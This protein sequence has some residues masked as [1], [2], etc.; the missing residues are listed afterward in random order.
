VI[1]CC[2]QITNFGYSTLFSRGIG[3]THGGVRVVSVSVCTPSIFHLYIYM[4]ASTRVCLY[5]VHTCTHRS[6]YIAFIDP[7][8]FRSKPNK[9]PRNQ[10]V[11]WVVG[12]HALKTQQKTPCKKGKAVTPRIVQ[13]K[14]ALDYIITKN[15]WLWIQCSEDEAS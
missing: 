1:S 13:S 9:A 12:D 2:E 5:D 14:A 8:P 4:F 11:S 10:I 15:V 7:V 3:S 6:T